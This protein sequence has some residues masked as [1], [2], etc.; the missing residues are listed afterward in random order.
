M[1]PAAPPDVAPGGQSHSTHD[2]VIR[3][4]KAAPGA[5]QGCP[6]CKG[7]RRV[8]RRGSRTLH[9]LVFRI[10]AGQAT[11]ARCTQEDRHGDSD[12][13]HTHGHGA[14]GFREVV[15]ILL[16]AAAVAEPVMAAVGA[17][18]HVLIVTA[19][20]VLGISAVGLIGLLIW[21]WQRRPDVTRVTHPSVR[22][23]AAR[24]LPEPQ[25]AIERPA[26][27]L[28]FHGVDAEDVAAIIRRHK[29]EDLL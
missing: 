2:T 10:R 18:V 14:P 12:D 24:P 9:R 20:V 5:A 1:C 27:H 11:A 13:A 22:V 17:I 15:L 25:Q 19:A 8:R 3:P 4:I 29:G 16:A 28:H 7:R 23:Q 26:V 6:R 21:R